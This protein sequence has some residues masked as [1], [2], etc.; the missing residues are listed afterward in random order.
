[1]LDLGITCIFLGYSGCERFLDNLAEMGIK[2]YGP[3]RTYWRFVWV[4]ASPIIS[5]VSS[6]NSWL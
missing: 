3:I 5:L 6:V 4:F 2:F 1:M